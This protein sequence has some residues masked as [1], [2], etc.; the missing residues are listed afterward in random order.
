MS[1]KAIGVNAFTL[2][3]ADAFH[4][5]ATKHVIALQFLWASN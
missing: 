5:I 2:N 3:H 4:E 1:I